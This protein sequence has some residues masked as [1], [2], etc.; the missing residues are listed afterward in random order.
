MMPVFLRQLSYIMALLVMLSSLGARANADEAIGWVGDLPVPAEAMIETT[1]GVNFDSPSGRVIQFTF[2]SSLSEQAL[3]DFYAMTLPALGWQAVA[4]SYK[5][6]S[7]LMMIKP[8]ISH[9]SD[10]KNAYLLI[11][12]PTD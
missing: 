12:Q 5:K 2:Y 4:H 3:S 1:S 6:G 10:G 8:V 11:V 9:R 7:E